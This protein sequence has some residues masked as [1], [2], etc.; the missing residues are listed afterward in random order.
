MAADPQPQTIHEA[1]RMPAP[2]STW[3]G[4]VLLFALFGVMALA[5]VGP[6]PRGTTYER[7]R[8][9]KRMDILKKNR[10]EQMKL[11]SKY[12]WIDK[13]KGTARIPVDRAME[14]TVAQLAQQKPAPAYPIASP[15][16]AS[17]AA[18]AP[19]AP[20]PGASAPPSEPKGTP[21]VGQQTE[22]SET[23]KQPAAAPQVPPAQPGTQPNPSATPAAS[24]APP[25]AKAA[26]SP[27]PTATI[28]T[29]GT[30]IPVPGKSPPQQ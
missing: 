9:N 3:I 12:S 16:A 29:A 18:P 7:D 20:A 30:P 22:Q 26:Q 25:A 27:Q 13:S 14:L 8:G 6:A 5:I 19:A 2:F 11:T 17:T 23:G 21:R 28:G 4:F 10:D 15:P 24:P 1:A